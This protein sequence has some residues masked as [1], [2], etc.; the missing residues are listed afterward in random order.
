MEKNQLASCK[1]MQGF[2]ISLVPCQPTARIWLSKEEPF[3]INQWYSNFC[4][5]QGFPCSI[6]LII[7][8][9][10]KKYC[11]RCC[12]FPEPAEQSGRVIYTCHLCSK[13]V[14]LYLHDYVICAAQ[15]KAKNT[16]NKKKIV[17]LGEYKNNSK[18][19]IDIKQ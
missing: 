8:G 3:F 15:G 5:V 16:L 11:A 9:T 10:Y 13:R 1:Q 18:V 7:K 6:C 14:W 2:L 4:G 19:N 17:C 12:F